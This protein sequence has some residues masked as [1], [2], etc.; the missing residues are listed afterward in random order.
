MFKK[1]LKFQKILSYALIAVFAVTFLYSIS[2]MT[3]VYDTLYAAYDPQLEIPSLGLSGEKVSGAKLFYDM[4]P[5]NKT[6]LYLA[7]AVI[8]ASL[9]YFITGS[10]GRRKYYISNY[11]SAGIIAAMYLFDAV[12]TVINVT[13]YRAKYLQ[14]DFEKLKAYNE[15]LGLPYDVSTFWFDMGYVIAAILVIAAGLVIFNVIWKNRLMKKENDLL[16]NASKEVA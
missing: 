16:T 15:P 12:Y 2:I 8:V 11:V 4:Q 5:F 6:L 1:Q 3:H 13:I 9:T 14:V 10:R 7:L